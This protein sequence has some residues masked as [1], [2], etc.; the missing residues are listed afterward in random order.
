MPYALERQKILIVDD[1]PANIKILGET[2]RNDY[3]V[4]AATSGEAALEVVA[5]EKPDLVLLDIV[6]PGMDGFEVLRRLKNLDG[7]HETPVIFITARSETVDEV[8]GLELG[9]VD[10][11]VKPFDLHIVK[12]RARTHLALKRKTDLLSKLASLD[13]L[14]DIPNRRMFEE[15]LENEWRRGMRSGKPL[16]IIMMDIDHFKLFND[17]YGHAGGDECLKAVARA[18]VSCLRRPGD[19]VG[20]YGGEEFVAVLPETDAEGARSMAE[21]IRERVRGLAITHA[22]S[23]VAG[24]VTLSFGAACAVPV[25]GESAAGLLEAADGMLYAA[26]EGGRDRGMVKKSIRETREG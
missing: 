20:R 25:E 5:R 2:F 3:E 8:A 7:G 17:N 13:G 26:K 14:T 6:M 11:I 21:M 23:S 19:F 18:L 12:A 15:V 1:V 16:S 22:F 9:A 4:L 24:V 10:Y